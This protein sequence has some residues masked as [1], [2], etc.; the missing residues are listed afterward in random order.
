[1]D[2]EASCAFCDR[3]AEKACPRCGRP[4]CG[5]HGDQFCDAC[6]DPALAVPS[7]RL[8]RFVLGALAACVVLGI[9]LVVGAPGFPGQAAHGERGA[10]N[11]S[12]TAAGEQ[13]TTQ[14]IPLAGPAT[15]AAS[16]TAAAARNYTVQSGDTIASIAAAVGAAPSAIQ[17]LNPTIDPNNLQIGQT[18]HL[19]AKP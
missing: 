4:Y 14:A 18:L 8:F 12:G 5:E 2:D 11:S 15:A 6:L 19:P 7:G 10:P 13:R 3:A 17:Q 9:W 1:M 16:A